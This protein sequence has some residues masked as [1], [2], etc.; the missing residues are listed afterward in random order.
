M[1][2]MHD[3]STLK[4]AIERTTK[5][6]SLRPALGR[7]TGVSKT[8]VI[9]GLTCESQEGDWKFVI[10]MPASV[11]G[12][13][14]GPTPGVMGRAALGSC[15]AIGYMM[16]AAT[17]NISIQS[18]EVQV[19]ADYDDGSLFGTSDNYPGYLQVR[20]VVNIESE[21]SAEEITAMLDDADKHSPYLDV[22]SRAQEC[23][24]EVRIVHKK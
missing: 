10:D 16:K 21:A 20:Y 22:F 9:N 24:R 19:E 2:S 8:K 17:M 4:T 7:S 12:N 14:S 23:I 3:T 5:A 1:N 6:L 15:L 11:G 13:G 18:L